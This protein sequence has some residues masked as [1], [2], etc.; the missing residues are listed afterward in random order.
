VP[1]MNDVL[2]GIDLDKARAHKIVTLLLRDRVLIRLGDELVFHSAALSAL[3][4]TV[5]AH[6]AKSP[7]IDVAQFKE[8]TQVSRKYAIPLLEFL[9]RERVTRRQGDVRVIL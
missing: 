5:R 7:T 6:K 8:I 3:R 9:D 4:T 1:A 2:A